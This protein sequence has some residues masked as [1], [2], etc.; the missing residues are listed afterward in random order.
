[1]PCTNAQVGSKG[2]WLEITSH[3]VFHTISHFS[4]HKKR[5]RPIS[6][7]SMTITHSV[8]RQNFSQF[9]ECSLKISKNQI[10][11][12]FFRWL[13]QKRRR[14]SR[15]ARSAFVKRSYFTLKD[16]TFKLNSTFDTITSDA[17]SLVIR[18][19]ELLGEFA[20][21]PWEENVGFGDLINV[22]CYW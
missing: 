18:Q 20:P 14:V 19:L 1:M 9:L 15:A 6:A 7:E 17:W 11:W 3:E 13:R 12:T 16:K 2:G 21:L 22:L 4:R 8:G 5:D 10:T